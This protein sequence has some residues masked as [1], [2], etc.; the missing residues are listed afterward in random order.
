MKTRLMSLA[1]ATIVLVGIIGTPALADSYR[2][3]CVKARTTDIWTYHASA[4]PA[5]VTVA[6]RG[7]GDTD[8]DVVVVEDTG[9]IVAADRDNTDFCVVRFHARYG[10]RYFIRVINLGRIANVYTM[11]VTD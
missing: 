10:H 8:L 11:T 5:L 6:V 3:D 2:R 1:L 7:D 4:R 9:R